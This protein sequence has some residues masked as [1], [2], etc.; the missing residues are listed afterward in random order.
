MDEADLA[1]TEIDHRL[2]GCIAV[3][4]QSE[5]VPDTGECLNCGEPLAPGRRWCDAG[6]RDDWVRFAGRMPP[7]A[8]PPH[9]GAGGRA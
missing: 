1:Q 6:C 2:R 5:P 9:Q 7:P 4:A 8:E 3:A